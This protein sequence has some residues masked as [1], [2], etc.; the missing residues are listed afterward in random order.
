MVK[1]KFTLEEASN[2]LSLAFIETTLPFATDNLTGWNAPNFTIASAQTATL[3]LLTNLS[4]T[5][6]SINLFPSL[7]PTTDDTQE[8]IVTNTIL[9]YTGK[10]SDQIMPVTYTVTGI[11]NSVPYTLT[12]F[13]Y[14][15]IFN[16]LECCKAKLLAKAAQASTNCSCKKKCSCGCEDIVWQAARF[17][18][19]FE[20]M[21]DAICDNQIPAARCTFAFL[22]KICSCNS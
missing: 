6:V 1:T 13:K 5:P 10:I 8:Y 9:G 18:T 2:S 3:S 20:A 12:A 21:Q 22:Q 4:A 11:F 19:L 15:G 17:A 7:F 16:A 14:I